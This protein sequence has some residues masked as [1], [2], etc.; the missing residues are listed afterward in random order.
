MKQQVVYLNP[1]N[2]VKDYGLYIK[3]FSATLLLE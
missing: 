1:N 2:Y 3:S